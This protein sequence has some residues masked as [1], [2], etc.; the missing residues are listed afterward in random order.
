[1]SKQTSIAIPKHS[2]LV[3]QYLVIRA[4]L[5]REVATRFGEYKLGFF[6]MLFEPLIG[7]VIIGIVIGPLAARSVP[8]IPYP[9]FLLHGMLML[10]LFTGPLNSAVGAISSNHGLLVYPSVKPLDPFI[11]RFVFDLMT[12]VFSFTLF[13]V[14]GAWMGVEFSLGSLHILA[15]GYIITWLI[16]CGLGL[17]FGVAAAFYSEVDKIVPILQRPLLFVSAVLY[18]T[19]QLPES[20][21]RLLFYNPLVHNIELCRNALF[22]NYT[23]HGA[24]LVYPGVFAIVVLSLGLTLFHSNRNNLTQR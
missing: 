21:Q 5:S 8:E 13:C 6:W 14:V 11:A 2:P 9:F 18:P 19:S 7:V 1:M 20:A 23:E 15:G 16:G 4:L 22:P 10:K 24:N 12:V 17:I 3:S